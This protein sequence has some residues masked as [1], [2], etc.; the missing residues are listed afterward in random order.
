MRYSIEEAAHVLVEVSGAGDAL[1][2]SGRV[3]SV[4]EL[5]ALGAEIVDRAML[6]G[7]L[8]YDIVLG[9]FAS[10]IGPEAGAIPRREVLA[11]LAGL[12]DS[13]DSRDSDVAL[14]ARYLIEK[15]E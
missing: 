2:L 1:G 7:D 6:I 8:A 3:R 14:L 11:G 15:L 4:R 10:P 9:F 5:A 13:R 12:S